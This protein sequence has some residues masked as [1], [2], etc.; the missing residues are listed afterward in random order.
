MP[1]S[2]RTLADRGTVLVTGATG[3]LGRWS[4]KPL[5][6]RGYRVHACGSR[7][8]AAQE[9]PE[10]LAGATYSQVNLFDPQQVERCLADLR[11]SHLLHFAWNAK[12][13]IYWTDPDNFDWVAASLHLARRFR[14]HGGGRLVVAGTCAEYDWSVA[15]ICREQETPTV[16]DSTAAGPPYAICKA[17][18]QRLLDSFGRQSGLSVGWGRVFLQFGP[19]EPATR[20]VPAII[21]ALLAGTPAECSHGRQI[22]SFLHTQDLGSAFAALLDS[23]I[24]GAINVGSDRQISISE[25][26]MRIGEAIGRPDLIKLGARPAAAN[27]PVLLVPDV[28][29]LRDELGWRPTM[30]LD[31]GLLRTIEWWRGNGPALQ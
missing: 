30:A 12:P 5:L 28:T 19:Y 31:D 16:L 17:T 4:V 23:G 26:V 2:E 18:L 9:L 27:E 29:R 11:P 15:D 3:F 20:L 8:L 21:N 25:L 1:T 10:E 14:H 22:R 6:A 24:S 7:S 13:G